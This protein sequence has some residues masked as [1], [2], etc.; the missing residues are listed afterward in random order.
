VDYWL[1]ASSLFWVEGDMKEANESL[2]EANV[3]A[4]R[5]PK[6]GAYEFQRYCCSL[7]RHAFD[8]VPMRAI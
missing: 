8:E 2:E 7:L 6:A 5:L 4:Q 3:L 1:A